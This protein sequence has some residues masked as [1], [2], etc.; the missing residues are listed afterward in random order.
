DRVTETREREPGMGGAAGGIPDP[1]PGTGYSVLDPS[2]PAPPDP[3]SSRCLW[4]D[5]P[6]PV[7]YERINARVLEM[8]AGGLPDEARA[9]RGL[10]RPLSREAGQAAGYREMFD[11]LDG[12]ASLAA[13]VARVQARTRQLARR[14]VT[15]FRHLPGC[16]P[17]GGRL[18]FA[19]WGLTIPEAT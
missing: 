11:H 12:R 8:G 15:W 6:R 1:I 9:P 3:R 2:R 5:L 19:E 10:G 7:L 18:T 16:R 13:A 14:Q 4:L 17:A